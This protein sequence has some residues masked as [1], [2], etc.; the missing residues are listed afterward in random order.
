MNEPVRLF[1]V[2]DL[3]L[4]GRYDAIARA[5]RAAEVFAALRPLLERADIV[6]GNMECVL[7]NSGDP[8]PDKLCVRAD[9]AYAGV[10]A[11]AGFDLVSLANNHSFDYGAGGL[12]D[13]RDRLEAAGVRTLG[14]GENAATA[15]EPVIVQRR[16]LRIG[17]L[18]F[19]HES[20]R[21]SDVAA[22]GKPGVAAL[23]SEAV[24]AA[25]QHWRAQV[26]QLVLLL[27]WGLE[28]SPLPTPEQVDLA[29]RAIDAGAGAVIGHH[30][31]MVQGVEQYGAGVIAYSLGNCTD[32]DVD[33]HGPE[34]HY[35]ARMTE[36]DRQGLGLLLEL[37]AEQ[38]RVAELCP[39]WLN[40]RGQPEPATGVR[41]QTI[42]ERIAERSAA[43]GEADLSG[44]WEADLVNRRVMGP[45]RHWW[46]RGSLLDKVRGFRLS[47]VRTLLLLLSTYARIRWSRSERRWS[48]FS[49]RNDGRPMPYA[50]KDDGKPE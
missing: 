2:G 23:E 8:R 4:G 20:T 41:G 5:G 40:D 27:H 1:A 9:P 17:F 3:F 18:A 47:Q 50:G 45:L 12:V 43:L 22:G 6:A 28:Y 42:L 15:A 46:S 37:G 33:W 10:L 13:T 32:A 24:I 11:A 49:P 36:S 30:S 29:R 7:G 48:L 34:R 14:A 31:H 21:P 35:S 16:G 25:V 26:D 39:L 44:R 38:V 19:C